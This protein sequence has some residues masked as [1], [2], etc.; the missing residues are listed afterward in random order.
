MFLSMLLIVSVFEA[1]C[2]CVCVCFLAGSNLA[3]IY[4]VVRAKPPIEE[5]TR[6]SV[7]S[8]WLITA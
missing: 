3:F 8:T 1:V 4:A 6:N 2:A 7:E 5:G